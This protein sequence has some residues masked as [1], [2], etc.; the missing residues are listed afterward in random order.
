MSDYNY[1]HGNDDEYWDD[2]YYE[3]HGGEYSS[4]SSSSSGGIWPIILAL[5]VIGLFTSI[6]EVLGIMAAI[7][8]IILAIYVSAQKKEEERKRIKEIMSRKSSNE[9]LLEK[10]DRQIAE[11]DR[12]LKGLPNKEDSDGSAED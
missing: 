11:V 9:L 5:I 4:G 7:A 3:E 2:V 6:S 1:F 10:W 8:A 12:L